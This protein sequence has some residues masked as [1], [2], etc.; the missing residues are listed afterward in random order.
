[1]A[2]ARRLARR[3]Q[4]R[5]RAPLRRVGGQ[6]ADARVGRRRRRDGPGRARPRPLDVPGARSARRR[7]GRGGLDAATRLPI[8]DDELPD[9]TAFIAANLVVDGMLTTCVAACAR[10]LGRADGAARAQDPPGGGLAPRPRRGVGEAAVPRGPTATGSLRRIARDLGAGRALARA[11][12]RSRLSRRA[13]GG[14]DRAAVRPPSASRCAPGCRPARR[15]RAWRSRSRSRRDWSRWDASDAA[16]DAL[17]CPFCERRRRRARRA[18]GRADHHRPVA[19]PGVQHV[20]R[21]VRE[22]FDDPVPADPRE[23]R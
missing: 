15:A 3:Q 22:D 13:R 12:R 6:R 19:L 20:L 5:A 10:Q 9:W 18:V 11:R 21:G 7:A 16:V 14:H 17:T 23:E 1:M 8:L 2:V 4:G